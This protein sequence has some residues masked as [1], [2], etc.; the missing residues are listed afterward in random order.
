MSTFT[1]WRRPT[2]PVERQLRDIARQGSGMALVAHLCATALLVLFSLASFVSLGGD[3]LTAILAEWHRG[4]GLDVPAAIS[5]SVITLMV[6]AFDVGMLY[7][8]SMLRLLASRR[9]GAR[10]QWV[11]VVVMCGVAAIEASTYA[12]MAWRYEAPA[13]ALAWGLIIVRAAA[14]P[15]LAVY[16]SMARPLPV[17]ARDILAQAELA[18]GAGVIRDVVRVAQDGAAPLDEKMALYGAS[19]VMSH[20]DRRRLDAMLD[21]VG[22]MQ[23]ARDGA[24]YLPAYSAPSL[25]MPS[26]ILPSARSL[27]GTEEEPP[28]PPDPTPS[29]PGSRG[30]RRPAPHDAAQRPS[31]GTGS[32]LALV[33]PDSGSAPAASARRRGA[34]G[35]GRRA[36]HKTH[37]REAIQA[38][39]SARVQRTAELLA[40]NP[41][42]T[43]RALAKALHCG[44]ETARWL[45]ENHHALQQ[46]RAG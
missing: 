23:A 11:H 37:R 4:R 46:R 27:T 8:A 35:A 18:S 33:S 32:G 22:Q 28:Q 20:D 9:A 3:T 34:R 13:T 24:L 25:P 43:P 12:Y 16:L 39:H 15:L 2:D 44:W 5:L 17:T 19:A 45:I 36:A 42:M 38:L 7:A 31:A 14:A 40:Q 26:P 6:L 21:V 41:E 10:E 30:H 29:P 1:L